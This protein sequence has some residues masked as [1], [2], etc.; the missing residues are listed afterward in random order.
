MDV[1]QQTT[2]TY[3]KHI[4]ALMQDTLKNWANQASEKVIERY[5]VKHPVRNVPA[6]FCGMQYIK[7]ECYLSKDCPSGNERVVTVRHNNV[8]IYQMRFPGNPIDFQSHC[9]FVIQ[10]LTQTLRNIE[11]GKELYIDYST[12]YNFDSN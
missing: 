7:D 9:L 1:R 4:M 10:T 3:G 8:E 11:F 12:L 5:H 6:L 2:R